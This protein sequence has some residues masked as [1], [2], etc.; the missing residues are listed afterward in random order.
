MKLELYR[1]IFEVSSDFMKIRPLGS[2]LFHLGGRTGMMKLLAPHHFAN[3]PK[4]EKLYPEIN[5]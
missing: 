5:L 4:Q 3:A 1:Q 2:E